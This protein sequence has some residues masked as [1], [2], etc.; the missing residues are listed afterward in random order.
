MQY[1]NIDY[2]KST[3]QLFSWKNIPIYTNIIIN[4]QLLYFVNVN[5]L[6]EC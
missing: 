6:Y 1:N 2:K 4:H 3:T 5:L